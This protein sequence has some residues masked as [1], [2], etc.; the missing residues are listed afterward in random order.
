M[1]LIVQIGIS[2]GYFINQV[3]MYYFMFLYWI[4]MDGMNLLSIID[5]DAKKGAWIIIF[6]S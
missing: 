4:I 2:I 5:S 1:R 6:W 3:F